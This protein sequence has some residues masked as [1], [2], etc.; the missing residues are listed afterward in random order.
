MQAEILTDVNIWIRERLACSLIK[1]SRSHGR[2]DYICGCEGGE[3]PRSVDRQSSATSATLLWSSTGSR[4]RIQ[5]E[6]HSSPP[7]DGRTNS[8]EFSSCGRSVLNETTD[9]R[10]WRQ[11]FISIWPQTPILFGLSGPRIV[12]AK[13]LGPVRAL[14]S[15]GHALIRR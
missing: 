11:L 1:A 6:L 7:Q 13:E 3:F 14:S 9:S 15:H 12:D 4:A 8:D 5:Y 2:L 10:L